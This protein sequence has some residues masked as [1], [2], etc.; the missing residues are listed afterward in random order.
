MDDSGDNPGDEARS[1]PDDALDGVVRATHRLPE[2]TVAGLSAGA[3]D[4]ARELMSREAPTSPAHAVRSVPPR[5][6]RW[7]V[8]ALAAAAV[9]VVAVVAIGGRAT[10]PASNANP[11]GAP[12]RVVD[13]S[14]GGAPSAVGATAAASAGLTNPSS[15]ASTS[16]STV[17]T[18]ESA[19]PATNS[20]SADSSGV[21]PSAASGPLPEPTCGTD[22]AA[23]V[24]GPA[25][26]EVEVELPDEMT[27]D[28]A[29]Q[30]H[31]KVT[32]ANGTGESLGIGEWFLYLVSG[33]VVVGRIQSVDYL[34]GIGEVAPGDTRT[35]DALLP[36]PQG[37]SGAGYD[38]AL[39][40]GVYNAY[41]YQRIASRAESALNVGTGPV[42]ITVGPG[43]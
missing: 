26:I 33:G 31:A 34:S 19:V 37:C 18:T 30:Q 13:F 2:A 42:S 43:F 40:S 39:P 21:A 24:G 27:A 28:K 22:A 32:V 1:E 14:G 10:G 6:R 25:G 5:S 3:P 15:A 16:A 36:A 17:E 8:P 7:A 41:W 11:A 38:G 35:G 20:S 4:I 29:Y 9:A 23:M 12:T